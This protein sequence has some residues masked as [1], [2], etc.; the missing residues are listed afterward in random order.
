RTRYSITRN[1]DLYP[2]HGIGPVA[3]WM[4]VNRGNQFD[5]LVSM[6]SPG[7]GLNLWAAEHIGPQSPEATQHYALGDVINTLIRT[8]SGQ[9][10]LITH[11]TNSPRPYSRKILL[12]GTKGVVR[13]YPEPRVHIAGRSG[14]HAW[15]EW[16]A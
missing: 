3:Q 2:T 11:D 7:R 12:Q 15:E 16:D 5:H 9:S 10:I 6:A 14:D 8:V 4:N 13:K 1:A